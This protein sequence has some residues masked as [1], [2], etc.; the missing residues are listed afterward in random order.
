MASFHLSVSNSALEE[1][2]TGRSKFAMVF[3][4]CLDLFRAGEISN[5]VF[6]VSQL[7]GSSQNA[8]RVAITIVSSPQISVKK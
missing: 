2:G 6:G 5:Y 4:N 1:V 8:D 7:L 3:L